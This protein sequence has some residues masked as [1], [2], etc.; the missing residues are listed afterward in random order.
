MLIRKFEIMFN[1]NNG[2]PL[3]DKLVLWKN[4]L[5]IWNMETD[6]EVNFN[7]L[8]E[9]LNYNLGK[10]TIRDLIERTDEFILHYNGGRGASSGLMGGGF[11]SAGSTG[12]G[13]DKAL[14][15]ASFNAVNKTHNSYENTLKHFQQKYAS[16]DH[17]FGITVDELGY[18][19]QHIEGGKSSVMIGGGK[20]ETVIHNHPSGGNFSS[21]DLIST[22]MDNSKGIVA[23]G[24]KN[25]KTTTFSLQKESH[26]KASQFAK[27]V[28]KAQWPTKFNYDEGAD[29]WLK[30]NQSKY[31]YTYTSSFSRGI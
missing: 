2:I 18:V 20:G 8:E 25:G 17:E 3:T 7:S 26:F 30:K 11:T 31:G 23:T 24:T 1:N 29:W 21:T 10:E 5:Q 12:D 27:A 4:P 14:F 15:P 13:F 28:K 9:V 19:S 16:S 6:E 22:A